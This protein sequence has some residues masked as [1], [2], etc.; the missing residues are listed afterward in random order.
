MRVHI[1]ESLWKVTRQSGVT[2]GARGAPG[3]NDVAPQ[4][5]GLLFTSDKGAS[6]FLPMGIGTLPTEA[7]L[8][9]LPFDRLVDFHRKATPL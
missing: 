3:D 4:E 1:E 7:E 5:A 8:A 9:A 2:A 6:R